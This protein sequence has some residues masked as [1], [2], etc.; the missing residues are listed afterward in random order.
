MCQS[1]V[2]VIPCSV[3][4]CIV[5]I[6]RGH[7][8]ARRTK[9]NAFWGKGVCGSSALL[10]I[11]CSH[12]VSN[13]ALVVGAHLRQRHGEIGIIASHNVSTSFFSFHEY[14]SSYS[15]SSSSTF[16]GTATFF[17]NKSLRSKGHVGF[18]FNHGVM[19]SR[20]NR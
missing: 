13:V 5:S 11:C 7:P 10:V 17:C 14:I 6:L 18:N 20:S 1:T 9:S 8:S 12:Q 16:V 19:H 3:A 4:S 15:S 2:M